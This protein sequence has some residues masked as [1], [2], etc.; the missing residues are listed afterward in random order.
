MI[1]KFDDF[2]INSI[3]NGD[4]WKICDFMVANADRLKRYFPKT[5]EQS[6]N[7]TLSKLYVEKSEKAFKD[8]E[9]FIFTLKHSETRQLA[10]LVI[11]KE[12][13]WNIKQGEFAYC[14]GY[15]F[16][17]RGLTSKAICTL[18]AYAFDY[19]GLERLQIIAH[20]DNLP[21]INVAI[22][23]SFK[24]QK[25]LKNEFTPTGEKPLDMELY[26]LYKN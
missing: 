13:D 7:P 5:L 20:K 16:E 14:I 19:L 21:S 6:L 22:N 3:H 9:L 10:G 15:P 11:I 1:I 24:W 23:N 4:A 25:T 17:G 12:L 18:S 26:E 2:E 8:K